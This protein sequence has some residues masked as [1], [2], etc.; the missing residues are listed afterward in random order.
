MLERIRQVPGEVLDHAAYHKDYARQVEDLQGVIWKLE[1]AQ[2]FR[3][4]GDTSWEAFMSGDWDRALRL[5][6][7]DRDAVRAEARDNAK[8]GLRIQRVRVVEQPV[9]PYLQWELNALRMLAEEGFGLRVLQASCVRTLESRSRLPEIVVLGRRVLYEV[10]YR[11]DWTPCGARRIEAPDVI[12][13]A[14]TEIARLYES[15]ESLLTFFEREI[16]PLPSPAA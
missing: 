3:E 8:Q 5:L 9:T 4:P 16:A 12:Q 13:A 14:A 15:G 1:R 10:R 6:E 11:D 7:A 2:T